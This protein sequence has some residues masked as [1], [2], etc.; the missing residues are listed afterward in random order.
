MSDMEA[1]ERCA[2]YFDAW[3][4][5]DAD[6]VLA[7]FTSDGTYCDPASGGPLRGEALKGY[8]AGLWSAFP[9]LS[10]E[11]TSQG[12]VGENLVA[13]QWTMR[14]TNHGSMM[15]L[16]PTGKSVTVSGADFI[17][18]ANG[19]IQTVDG[20][21]DSRAVP[22]QL[23]LQVL[24]QP[25]EIGPFTFGN[26]TRASLGKGAKPGAFSI[27][28]LES[29]SPE[30]TRM[31]EQQSSKIVGEMMSMSGFLGWVGATV[32][33]RMMTISAWESAR[34][35]RQL[36]TGGSHAE[37]MKKFFGTELASGGFT[38]V[39]VPDRI[40]TRWVRCAACGRMADHERS[41]G[42]CSCGKKLPDPLAYW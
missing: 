20:Y 33:R 21:F 22:E 19:R 37:A 23:G 36:L 11:I 28:V 7:T 17:R 29:R 12:L 15:G 38:S 13:A 6:A 25:A 42:M 18:L 16:P 24:V 27:T 26:A 14:G 8:M 9:D 31:V 34:D 10:F 2:Q 40:N 41:E 30:E 32:G 4:R 39:W 35:P 5:R 3:N 1:L